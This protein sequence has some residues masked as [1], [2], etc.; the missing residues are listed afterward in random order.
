MDWFTPFIGI[1]TVVY[2]QLRVCYSSSLIYR[3]FFRDNVYL[4]KVNNR[5]ARKRREIRSK[6][7]IKTPE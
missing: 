1:Y 4:F 3:K 6:L 2:F 5:S 7:T